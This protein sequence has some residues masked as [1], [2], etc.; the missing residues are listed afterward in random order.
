MRTS[1]PPAQLSSTSRSTTGSS[2]GWTEVIRTMR[3]PSGRLAIEKR[4]VDSTGP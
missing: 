1:R 4:N 2:I 3:R